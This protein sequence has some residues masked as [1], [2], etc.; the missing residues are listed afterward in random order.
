MKDVATVHDGF[1][2]QTNIVRT[3]GTR[4]V[5]LTVTR[6][7]KAST[8]A[9]VNAVK[10]DAAAGSWPA[11]RQD[12]KLSVFGDQSLFVR[13]AIGGVVRETLI[14]ALLTGAGDPAVS[15]QLAQHADR[16]HLDSAVD[17]DVDLDPQPARPDHQRDDARRA[18]AGRRHPGG[19]CDGG[20]R[21]HASQPGDGEAAGAR[22]SG[23]RL[24]D[25]RADVRLHPVDL[26]RVRAGAAADGHGAVPVHAAGDGGG[27]RDDGVVP[28]VADAG[29]DDGALPAAQRGRGLPGRRTRR[30]R[31]ALAA[32][33]RRERAVRAAS[34]PLPG[35]AELCRSATARRC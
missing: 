7:G 28:A 33:S 29:A 34:L 6:N 2:P 32:S 20:D 25:R 35:P 14:A 5:L 18:G 10:D 31:A 11:S 15:R 22:G 16:L 9:V 23:R 17:P 24:A 1:V 4:G 19:R 8:L 12:L 26:H 30:H 21:E 3:N 27:V 13:A